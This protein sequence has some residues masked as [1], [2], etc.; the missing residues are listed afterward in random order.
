MKV[1]TN[2]KKIIA[3]TLTPVSVY[4]KLRNKYN[5]CLLLESSD[6][7]SQENNSLSF[8]CVNPIS[9]ISVE[10]NNAK[11]T[12][13][14]SSKNIRVSNNNFIDVF[15]DFIS[16]IKITK[17]N[18]DFVE[19]FN[20][21]FGYFAYTSVQYIES[22]NFFIRKTESSEIPSV[23]FSFFK[24]VIV[25]NH[26][27]SDLTIIENLKE[28]EKSKISEIEVLIETSNFEKTKFSLNGKENSNITD[29]EYKEMV[30]MVK[31]TVKEVM[32]FK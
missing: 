3:D 17:T 27:N 32:F 12:S 6:Y 25:F 31:N 26:F 20:G 8:I 18:N 13:G 15:N 21:L 10:N 2:T 5:N 30:K 4:L 23:N 16:D 22:I 9:T 1:K 7:N 28:N 19:K 14:N 24:Y 11:I 29:D